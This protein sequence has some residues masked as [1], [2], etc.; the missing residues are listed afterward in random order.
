MPTKACLPALFLLLGPPSLCLAEGVVALIEAERAELSGAEALLVGGV[1]CAVLSKKDSRISAVVP[2]TRPTEV[3]VWVRAY[4]TWGGSDAVGISFNAGEPLAATAR[5]DRSGRWDNGNFQVWHWIRAGKASLAKGAHKLEITP[6]RGAGERI[7]KVVLYEGDEPWQQRWLTGDLSRLREREPRF[8]LGSKSPL[9]IE[10]EEFDLIEATLLP[11]NDALTSAR[12][13]NDGAS[14]CTVFRTQKPLKATIYI[15]QFFEAKNMFEGYTMEEMAENCYVALD[16]ELIWTFFEQ[17][18]RRWH[19]GRA[20]LGAVEIPAGVHL[21]SIS[22]QGLPVRIDKVALVPEECASAAAEILRDQAHLLPFGVPN[23]VTFEGARRASDWSLFGSLAEGTD[24][25]SLGAEEG[26]VPF[27]VKLDLPRGAGQL[28]LEKLKPL[29]SCEARAVHSRDQRISVPVRGGGDLSVSVVYEDRH[30]ERYLAELSRDQTS[31]D[32]TVATH[33]VP[34][35]ALGGRGTYFDGTGTLATGALARSLSTDPEAEQFPLVLREGHDADGVPDYPLAITHVLVN[36]SKGGRQTLYVGEP[37]FERP[38]AAS[39][40]IT[41]TEP[42]DGKT[43]VTVRIGVSNQG[44]VPATVPVY[45]RTEAASY[46]FHHE[47]ARRRVLTRRAVKV[48]AGMSATLDAA[49][50]LGNSEVRRLLYAVGQGDPK[51]LL[52]GGSSAA[53]QMA[54]ARTELGRGRGAFQLDPLKRKDGRALSRSEVKNLHGRPAGFALLVDGLDVT[55]RAYADRLDYAHPLTVEGADLSDAAGWPLIRVPY[56]VVAVDP[57]LGRI[58][59]SEGDR[60][61][62]ASIGH[63]DIGFAVP[64]CGAPVIHGNYAIVPPGEGNHTAVDIS[65]RK[66]PKPVAFLPSW[67]F[68]RSL[69]PFRGRGY[70]ESSRRGLMMVD[71]YLD[72]PHRPGRL[73]SV[74]FDREKHGRFAHVFEEEAVAVSSGGGSLWFHDLAD[75]YRPREIAQ[76]AD[77]RGFSLVKSR[78]IAF[79]VTAEEV[80]AVDVSK[81]RK[82]RLLE[83]GLPRPRAV[84]GRKKREVSAGVASASDGWIALKLDRKFMLFRWE[85]RGTALSAKAAISFEPSQELDIPEGSGKHV[86]S[87]FNESHFYIIDGKGGP[88]QYGI[89]WGGARSRWFTYD[90]KSDTGEPVHTYEDPKPTAYGA[91]TI[92]GGYGY[93][94]DY[95]YGLWIFDLSDPARPTKLSGAASGGEGDACWTN[96][97]YVYVWQTFGGHLY[98]IDV[99]NPERPERRGTYWDGAWVPYANRFRGNYTVDGSGDY[100]FLP[101]GNRGLFVIDQ[102][103]PDEPRM[104]GEFFGK[105]GKPLLVGAAC[106]HVVDDR[107]YVV[108]AKRKGP[109]EMFIYDVSSPAKPK[110][111]ADLEVP[112]ATTLH[113]KGDV[114][115]LAG[116]KTFCLVGVVDDKPQLL[117]SMDLNEHTKEGQLIGGITVIRGHAYLT[118]RDRAP[119]TRLYIVNVRDSRKPRFVGLVDPTPDYMDAPCSSCWGDYYQDLVSD[120]QYLFIGDYAQIECFDV[121]RPEKPRFF[122]RKPLGYQWSC[123]RKWGEHLFVPG[124]ATMTVLDVPTSSQ[125]PTGKLTVK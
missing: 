83:G 64:G 92:D 33:I 84:V 7:D 22:K 90:L 97:R 46:D 101:R 13:T 114:L 1:E 45:L 53:A 103:N 25:R 96:G 95:N 125:V 9:Q 39:A 29:Q 24:A 118:S 32:W 23:E 63:S 60:E 35:D 27:P 38:F 106:I 31:T 124:L 110:L 50:L 69:F 41:K 12:L 8:L 43:R 80:R 107:A 79:V 109:S 68:S 16:G 14:L 18:G 93:I 116:D 11:E 75:P 86:F 112:V 19:W 117:S 76:I 54:D 52:I 56:G 15:R 5:N 61:P 28:V 49:F 30:G 99:S 55:S 42:A 47:V 119:V 122:G 102:T 105:D 85:A 70:V 21:L 40:S 17:D 2:I 57:E 98:T 34:L 65:D 91:V 78:S 81:P 89:R 123:G 108:R 71:G 6:L 44:P 62:M 20:G 104:V 120:G 4:F 82:P 87:A 94:N 10:A 72:N 74:L 73:R 111:I 59:F 48:E 26:V 115:Y 3:S 88:G 113:K 121:S 58:K 77:V 37:A 36:K 100:V 51:V 66:N 67:Y